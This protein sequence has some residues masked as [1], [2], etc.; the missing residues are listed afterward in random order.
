MF[1]YFQFSSAAA[2]ECGR[3]PTR[4]LQ[5]PTT[6]TTAGPGRVGSE[7]PVGA[8]RRCLCYFSRDHPGVFTRAFFAAI[9]AF[10]RSAMW[11]TFASAIWGYHAAPSCSPVSASPR[12]CCAL[13]ARFD[14]LVSERRVRDA[15]C[16]KQ[17]LCRP[18]RAA[19]A[20]GQRP[21]LAGA[22]GSPGAFSGT[23]ERSLRSA[24][25]PKLEPACFRHD[26]RCGGRHGIGGARA[27]S[28]SPSLTLTTDPDPHPS[29]DPNPV[30]N[31][32]PQDGGSRERPLGRRV[33]C[34]V[35]HCRGALVHP[36]D[37]QAYPYPY[38]Y[39]YP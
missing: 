15:P 30:P 29:P 25:W 18:A 28:L 20:A 5:A 13:N 36:G 9:A 23:A 8:R 14:A 32:N 34:V 24:S 4:L 33:R 22:W 11:F 31:H 37:G 26:R 1:N 35:R 17:R 19:H 12:A 21:R 7:T 27:V 3:P 39:P 6:R 10:S 16:Q 38:P 2:P